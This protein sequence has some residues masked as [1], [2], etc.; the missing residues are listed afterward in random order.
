VLEMIEHALL[1]KTVTL[2]RKRGSILVLD[3][4]DSKGPKVSN[5]A[6]KAQTAEMMNTT[7]LDPTEVRCILLRSSYSHTNL[8]RVT[9]F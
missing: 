7:T 6:D 8:L 9:F 2:C 5:Y 1:A 4:G 3:T